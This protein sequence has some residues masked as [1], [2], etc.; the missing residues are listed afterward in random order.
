MVVCVGSGGNIIGKRDLRKR[1]TK[2]EKNKVQKR[3]EREKERRYGW[4]SAYGK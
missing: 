1:K 2:N 3:R 4:E